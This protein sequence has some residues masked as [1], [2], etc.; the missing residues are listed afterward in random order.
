MDGAVDFCGIPRFTEAGLIK[1]GS[2]TT[3]TIPDTCTHHLKVIRG[4]PRLDV[5]SRRSSGPDCRTRK[6]VSGCGLM[7]IKSRRGG[8]SAVGAAITSRH[9]PGLSTRMA[10]RSVGVASVRAPLGPVS[11]PRRRLLLVHCPALAYCTYHT[12][13]SRRRCPLST[14]RYARR[15]ACMGR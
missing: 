14:S 6:G 3:A 5:E 10:K 15:I 4:D 1:R 8:P 11:Q 7:V 2:A 12:S 13:S 9:C